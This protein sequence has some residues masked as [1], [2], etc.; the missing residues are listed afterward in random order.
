MQ[1]VVRSARD[2]RLTAEMYLQLAFGEK[3]WPRTRCRAS[4]PSSSGQSFTQGDTTSPH[5]AGRLNCRLESVCDTRHLTRSFTLQVSW[6]QREGGYYLN[7]P[8]PKNPQEKRGRRRHRAPCTI[9][10]YGYHPDHRNA[11]TLQGRLLRTARR[12]AYS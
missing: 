3:P 4:S 11:N 12:G 1:P 8:A 10:R 2:H 6:A 5:C 9:S 7:S